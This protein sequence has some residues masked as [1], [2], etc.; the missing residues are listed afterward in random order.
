MAKGTTQEP[1]LQRWSNE[2]GVSKSITKHDEVFID[3]YNIVLLM[4]YFILIF[5]NLY[6]TPKAYEL[7]AL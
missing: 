5:L 7:Y 6:Y 2:P 3:H 1:T 4:V